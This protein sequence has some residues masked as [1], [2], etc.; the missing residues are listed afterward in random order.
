MGAALPVVAQ[1][2][3]IT[4]NAGIY[5]A[6]VEVANTMP[7]RME[8]LMFRRT[9]AAND[10]M[11]FVFDTVER[12]CMWMKNTYLPLSV[13]FIDERGV[14]VSI[15]DMEPQ[16]EQNHC[17][18]RPARFALEMNRGWFSARGLKAGAHLGGLDKAPPPR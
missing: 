11:L 17:A 4:L 12:Q 9:M 14:I 2:P 13:A 3:R 16:S 5:L 1:S 8:G 10:G 18:A 7:T 6:H 15:S